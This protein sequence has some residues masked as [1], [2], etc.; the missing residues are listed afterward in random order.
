MRRLTLLA[1]VALFAVGLSTSPAFADC[2][3]CIPTFVKVPDFVVSGDGTCTHGGQ[4][5]GGTDPSDTL[6][7]TVP[8]DPKCHACTVQ[9]TASWGPN[10]A[11]METSP[12]KGPGTHVVVPP[13]TEPYWPHN[14]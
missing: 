1:I 11:D 4:G 2:N 6:T 14:V 8:D 12:K 13:A 3:A 5:A 7:I 9:V 10:P